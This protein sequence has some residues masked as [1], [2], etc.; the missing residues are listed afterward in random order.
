MARAC[1]VGPRLRPVL[2]IVVPLAERPQALLRLFG[3]NVGRRGPQIESPSEGLTF[4]YCW[5]GENVWI[6]NLG[7]SEALLRRLLSGLSHLRLDG[8][9]YHP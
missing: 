1:P 7:Q 6:D 8:G 3:A 2:P 4:D 5:I 9:R